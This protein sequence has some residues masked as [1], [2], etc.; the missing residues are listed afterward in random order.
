MLFVAIDGRSGSG[1]STIVAYAA[2]LLRSADAPS[3]SA[4]VVV[5]DGDEFYAGGSAATWDKRTAEQK[6]AGAFDW[7][8]QL[9][10][11]TSLRETGSATWRAFDWGH[12]DWD[13]DLAPLAGERH[14]AAIAAGSL[15][16]LEG[17]CSGRPE[18]ADMFDLRVLVEAPDPLRRQRLRKREGAEYESDWTGRWDE[19]EQLYFGSVAPADGFDL[20]LSND[21]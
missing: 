11:L 21:R 18:L 2:T 15:V 16:I 4:T 7:G 13:S 9:G 3:P 14:S 1:K 17:A 20:V 8:R 10:V 5:L 19:A 6:V 12:D